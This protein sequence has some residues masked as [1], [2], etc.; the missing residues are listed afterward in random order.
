MISHLQ[1][2]VVSFLCEVSDW[3]RSVCLVALH[4]RLEYFKVR[5]SH[6]KT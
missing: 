4:S 5:D 1:V 6:F 3:R 2:T